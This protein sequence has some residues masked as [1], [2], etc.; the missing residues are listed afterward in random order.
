MAKKVR[1]IKLVREDDEEYSLYRDNLKLEH[2]HLRNSNQ[3]TYADL[4]SYPIESTRHA[5]TKNG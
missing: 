4:I 1:N 5:I 2:F 3:R